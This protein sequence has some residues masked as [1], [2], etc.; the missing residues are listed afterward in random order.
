VL[1]ISLE[2]DVRPEHPLP[3]SILQ[4]WQVFVDNVDPLTKALHVPTIRLGVQRAASNTESLPPSFEALMFAIYSAAVTSLKDDECKK[5]FGEGR[6]I[7][8]RR[9]LTATKVALSRAKFMGTNSL[10]VLQALVLYLIS[11]RYVSETRAIWSLTGVAIRIAQNMGLERDGVFLGLPP[12]ETEMRRRIWW[13]LKTHD[14][15]TAELCGLAKFRDLDTG[16]ERTK[17]PVNINDD[18]L[19]PNMTSLPSESDSL[20]DMLFIALKG[21][22]I[23]G[24]FDRVMRFRQQG[25]N[26]NQWDNLSSDK[27]EMYNA[28]FELEKILETK[29][30]RYCDPS[31][32]LHFIAMLTARLSINF[33]RFQAHHPRRWPSMELIPP[34]ESQLLWELSLKL[35]EQY[36]VVQSSTHIQGFSWHATYYFQWHAFIFVLDTLRTKPLRK[37]AEKAWQLI[38][39]TYMSNLNMMS[40]ARKPIHIAVGNLCLKAF[41][42]YE[43]AQQKASHSL[44]DLDFILML[45]QTQENVK[46]KIQTRL[47]YAN[48]QDASDAQEPGN[49]RPGTRAGLPDPAH[50]ETSADIDSF[51][52]INGFD[53][54][55]IP[56]WDDP[57]NMDLDLVLSQDYG[58]GGNSP[59]ISWETWDAWLADSNNMLHNSL[60]QSE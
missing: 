42:A 10:I 32:P 38:R 54:K 26:I 11:A 2:S 41:S 56:L 37:D 24:A 6:H 50:N 52:S 7:L 36:N 31:Q 20:T 22:L 18:Q 47:P 49:S 30:L 25:T 16:P 43:A 39:S 28:S 60:M 34:S 17:W 4:L 3:E 33:I 58:L 40:D 14:F 44:L 48:T 59:V 8:L 55:Q 53:D 45:R 35:L 13:L 57:M 1:G 46:S 23:N 9:Y 21:I 51:W 15:Q 27:A 5:R 19:H 29:Y 12:F